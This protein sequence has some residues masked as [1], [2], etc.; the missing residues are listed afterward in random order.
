LDPNVPIASCVWFVVR[1]SGGGQCVVE[2]RIAQGTD[3]ITMVMVIVVVWVVGMRLI[4]VVLLVQLALSIRE[5]L[6]RKLH[7][8]VCDALYASNCHNVSNNHHCCCLLL[9]L[10]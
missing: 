9:S 4:V 8:Q 5:E 6:T 2:L 10:L 1:A 7:A 3:L